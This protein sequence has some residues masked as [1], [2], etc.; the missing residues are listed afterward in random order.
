MN[1]E[2]IN[3]KIIRSSKYTADIAEYLSKEIYNLKLCDNQREFG[4]DAQ[5]SFGKK[6]QIKINNSSKKTNQS[7]GDTNQYDFL[8]LLITRN[9][10]LFNVKYINSF[11]T[12]YRIPKELI[13]EK[14]YIAKTIIFE[15]TPEFLISEEFEIA[16]N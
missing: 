7:V 3:N 4:F 13:D 10:R 1:S 6:Y 16:S 5:D 14:K 2:L 12:I 9:S 8:L 11:I 15:L